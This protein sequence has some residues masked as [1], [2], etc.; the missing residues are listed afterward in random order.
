MYFTGKSLWEIVTGAE[1]VNNE[2][3]ESQTK[4]KKLLQLT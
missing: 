4:N 2:A 3:S 1:T